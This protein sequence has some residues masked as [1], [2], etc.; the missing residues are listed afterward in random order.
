MPLG[1]AKPLGDD[2]M[3]PSLERRRGPGRRRADTEDE[4]R[5]RGLLHDLGHQMTTLSYLVEAVRAE[6]PRSEDSGFRLELL[7]AEM[8]R[9]LDLIDHGIYGL[10][11]DQPGSEE[12]VAL[13]PLAG[14]V[15]RLAAI[16]HQAEVV[17]LPGR[18]VRIQVSPALLW[19]VLTNVVDNAARAAGPGGR[20]TLAIS[21]SRETVIEVADTGPGFGRGAPGTASLGLEIVDSL[22][23]SC[24]GFLEVDSPPG[25]GTVVR[26]VLPGRTA[27]RLAGAAAARGA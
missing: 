8:S 19:R 9:V 10:H 5:L 25:G 13:R 27:R 16:A 2:A 3:E 23:A 26:I 21:Q 20:V 18:D 1:E 17:L 15:A 7:A 6:P 22:L 4:R 24:D 14:Q 11:H 12:P